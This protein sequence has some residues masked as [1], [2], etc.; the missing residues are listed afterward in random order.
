[1]DN[2][3]GSE[4]LLAG[5]VIFIVLNVTVIL[6]LLGA[7]YMLGSS[8]PLYEEAYAKQI[9][10]LIDGAKNNTVIELDILELYQA[11][12]NKAPVIV[13]INCDS[14]EVFVQVTPE[15]GYSFPF[16]TEFEKCQY[17]MDAQNKRLTIEV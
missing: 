14:N 15:G 13:K 1:M 12:D 5:T 3:R 6:I 8:P 4:D 7:V 2:K 17:K 10:L 16:F 9:A 11:A